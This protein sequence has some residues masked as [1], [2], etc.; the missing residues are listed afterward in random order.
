MQWFAAFR[1]ALLK[2][3]NILELNSE[4]CSV[5]LLLQYFEESLHKM[6]EMREKLF[7]AV[8]FLAT[9]ENHNWEPADLILTTDQQQTFYF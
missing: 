9:N 3:S 5:N 4:D 1:N 8:N 7:Q 2:I 6:K